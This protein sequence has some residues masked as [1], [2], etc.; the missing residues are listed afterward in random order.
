MPVGGAR[1]FGHFYHFR[2][3]F[4][5]FKLSIFL[6][7]YLPCRRLM[8]TKLAI[9][10]YAIYSWFGCCTVN[11]EWQISQTNRHSP[12]AKYDLDV[13]L[14]VNACKAHNVS[15]MTAADF[16]KCNDD[17]SGDYIG[18]WPWLECC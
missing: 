4:L 18:L 14:D 8:P 17:V 3:I 12:L 16:K 15:S 10:L 5:S 9:Y 6:P 7:A 1:C 11:P 2:T 13:T